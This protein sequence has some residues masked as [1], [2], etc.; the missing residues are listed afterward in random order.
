M[1]SVHLCVVNINRRRLNYHEWSCSHN[2]SASLKD[3][4]LN[5]LED[6]NSS[7]ATAKMASTERESWPTILS[8]RRRT[9]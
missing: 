7:T 2:T 1:L 9:S 3:V 8:Q 5:R 6:L 4:A